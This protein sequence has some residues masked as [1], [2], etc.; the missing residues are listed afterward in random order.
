MARRGA[1]GTAAEQNIA[2]RD[3]AAA[4]EVPAMAGHI[5]LRQPREGRVR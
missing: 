2:A 5:A 1:R 4:A 3:M